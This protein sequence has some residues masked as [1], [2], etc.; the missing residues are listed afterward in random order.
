ML[1]LTAVIGVFDGPLNLQ[2]H[3]DPN[4]DLV[5]ESSLGQWPSYPSSPSITTTLPNPSD[6]E[7]VNISREASPG[8]HDSPV[9]GPTPHNHMCYTCKNKVKGCVD[10]KRHLRE[11]Y[12]RWYC[13]PRNAVQDT[14][15]GPRCGVCKVPN[16]DPEHLNQHNAPTRTRCV[17]SFSRKLTLIQHLQKY[18]PKK[19]DD[20]NDYSTLAERSRYTGGRKYFACGFCVLGFRSLDMQISHIHDMHYHSSRQPSGYDAKK[21]ILGLLFMNE[22]WRDLRAA[23]PSLQDS[24]FTWNAAI[25]AKLQLRL[26][27]SEESAYA[28]YKAAFDQCNYDTS[29]A[30]HS[31]SMPGTISTNPQ[32]ETKQSMP[33]L[34][35]PQAGFPQPYSSHQGS[36]G[37]SQ[38]SSMTPP[39]AQPI[40][41]TRNE[42]SVNE[43]DFTDFYCSQ[44]VPQTGSE[45][46]ES[47]SSPYSRNFEYS[48]QP[49]L[50]LN[51]AE[52]VT[53]LQGSFCAPLNPQIWGNR[54]RVSYNSRFAGHFPNVSPN[55]PANIFPLQSP[56]PGFDPTLANQCTPW[57]LSP[58]RPTSQRGQVQSSRTTKVDQMQFSGSRNQHLKGNS[59]D[60]L[61]DSSNNNVQRVVHDKAD[62]RRLRR[63]H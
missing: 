15:N 55:F 47:P 2:S 52:S 29:K 43:S 34:Q 37:H 32:M 24:L 60:D 18:H 45:S 56:T 11:H 25:V 54:T 62:T 27:M 28:L 23:N 53:Q 50:S 1:W 17:G 8:P 39:G 63:R 20:V 4:E 7:S 48:P 51:N 3:D 31:E 16:P 44:L 33:L 61:D 5:A 10:F 21:V 36:P 35:S 22:Y 41:T 42:R 19:R 12:V 14:E 58:Y 6:Q 38:A 57:T 40:Q 9:N 30:C 49:Q 13:I 26:E 46:T 59:S